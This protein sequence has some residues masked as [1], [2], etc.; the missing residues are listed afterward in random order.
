MGM[1]VDNKFSHGEIVYLKTDKE[2]LPRMVYCIKVF[3]G[4]ILYECVCGTI[5]SAHYDFELST[6]INVLMKTDN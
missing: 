3:Q 2:Q 5:T 6:E 1:V 4:E